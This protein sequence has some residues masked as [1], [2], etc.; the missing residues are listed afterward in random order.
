MAYLKAR[1]HSFIDIP[2]ELRPG[3][4]YAAY[5]LDPEGNALELYYYME[6]IGWDGRARP[7]ELRRPVA[8]GAWPER[9]E[10]MSD[11]YAGEPFLGPLG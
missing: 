4:D 3:V 11:T 2:A 8:Q 1:G 9:L 5:L 6:Q 10:P 7:A